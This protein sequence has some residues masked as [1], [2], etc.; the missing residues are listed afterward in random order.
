MDGPTLSS[1]CYSVSYG[2]EK[3]RMTS[4]GG[5][6][7]FSSR[8][9]WRLSPFMTG[10]RDFHGLLASEQANSQ[11]EAARLI[12]IDVDKYPRIDLHPDPKQEAIM[13]QNAMETMKQNRGAAGEEMIKHVVANAG[14]ISFEV[15][16][17]LNDLND[18]ISDSKLRLYRCHAACTLVI[19]RI[20]KRLGVHDFD[21]DALYEFT[22]GM[23]RGLEVSVAQG[24]TVALDEA[25][26]RMMADLYERIVV[27]TEYRDARSSY[28]PETPRNRI[29]GT[30]AG[31]YI[32]GTNRSLERAGHIL[33]SQRAVRDWCTTNRTDYDAV[34]KHLESCGALVSRGSG[35]KMSLTRGTDIPQVQTRVIIVDSYKL[36]RAA[37]QVVTAMGGDAEN[38]VAFR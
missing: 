33:I 25:F 8:Q 9:T 17:T 2:T 3:A 30:V 6:V 15:R 13:V 7:T 20:A 24:N 29:H 22:V 10:N 14:E 23:L 34:L 35:E 5:S 18:V 12:Q 26:S 31:R 36:D 4:K 37:A 21:L 19:A 11:A 28:G 16:S 27:T 32:L 38:V 1:V